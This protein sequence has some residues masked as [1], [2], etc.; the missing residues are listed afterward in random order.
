MKAILFVGGAG[1]IGSNLIKMFC[2]D[3]FYTIFVLEPY[4]ANLSRLNAY[5][6]KIII[7]QGALSDED[8]MISIIQENNI[9]IVVHLVSTLIPGSSYI[10]Y[11]REFEN[12]I[13]PSIRLMSLCAEKRVKFVYFSSGG[14]VYGKGNN[15]ILNEMDNLAP[16][17]YYGLSKQILEN[18]IMFENRF[19]GLKYLIVRPSNPF[20]YGQALNASQGLIAVS[21]GKILANEPIEVWGN[22][23]S[24]RDYIFIDD[25]AYAFFQL[26]DN[27]VENE[28]INIGS[29]DGYSINEIIQLL[30]GVVGHK[31]NVKYENA[32]SV[33]VDRAVL[34]IRK[35]HSFIDVKKT[36]MEVSM[37]LFY[38][39]V[40]VDLKR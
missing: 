17:S 31:I 38:N 37:R 14:A 36:T 3:G 30:E 35:L 28:T 34:D 32:R 23:N 40:K 19:R 6:D 4:F 10:D 8:L 11:K 2:E 20:G 39:Q 33:D 16:I 18:S 15:E 29:G 9:Q 24:I 27:S 22:G 5:N 1:F 25:L 7:I 21:I 12:I 13:F 26:V